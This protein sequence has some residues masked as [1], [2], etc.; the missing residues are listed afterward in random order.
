MPSSLVT[1]WRD[2][3]ALLSEKS[4]AQIVGLAGEGHLRD[5]SRA[6]QEF[7]D[8]LEL[9]PSDRLRSY[10]DECLMKRF[11]DAAF[12]LQD[13]VNELGTRLGFAVEAGRYRGV[14]N[15]V[16]FDGIWQSS[17]GHALLIEVKT[18]DAY[19]INLDTIAT[20]R[21]QLVATNRIQEDTSSI[22]IAVGR[23]DTGD[24]E[25]Q[26]RGSRHAW[27]IRVIN[28]DALLR[29]I[30]V[31]ERMSDWN[32]SSRINL[33]LRPMEYTRVDGIIDLLFATA[34]DVQTPDD[35][36]RDPDSADEEVQDPE[37]APVRFD[38]D[39]ARA[40]ALQKLEAHLGTTLKK[41]GRVF[42][43]SANGR[44]NVV[45]LSSRPYHP[46]S[47][48]PVFWYGVKPGHKPF[49]QDSDEGYAL[50]ACGTEH[51]PVAIPSADLLLLLDTLKTTP[52]EPSD[53]NPLVHWHV[54]IHRP[55]ARAEMNTP[56]AGGRTD[57][58]RFVLQ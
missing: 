20:Y 32:T 34:A 48:A 7:R 21:R 47:E 25:A 50:F 51:D 26:I 31:K 40:H 17:D 38:H 57:I 36:D 52:P 8:L 46:D 4:C 5:G 13:V 18:T 3:T 6:S 43:S 55:G 14:R 1:L 37:D 39:R 30:E 35:T 10:A 49:L 24:L 33:L 28:I 11:D 23:E 56:L 29:L 12:A 58:T 41:K 19:R 15:Q 22:L 9:L 16:G 45:C 42:W 44:H 53:E 54:T 27:D 2:N